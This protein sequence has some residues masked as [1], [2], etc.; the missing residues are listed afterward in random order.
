M[1][2][3]DYQVNSILLVDDDATFH[4]LLRYGLE[5]EGLSVEVADS[6]AAARRKM[7]AANFALVVLDIGLPDEDGLALL[8]QI[9]TRTDVPIMVI[10]GQTDTEIVVT[11]LELGANDF[12]G[13]PFDPRTV[14]LKIK[15]LATTHTDTRVAKQLSKP[16]FG[17]WTLDLAGRCLRARDGLPVA[18]TPGE[19]KIL[20][21]LVA[22]P[23]QALSRS[24][25]LDIVSMGE[26]GPTPR[27]I[28]VFITGL[29]NKLE[30]NRNKPELITTVRGYGYRFDGKFR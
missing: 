12:V 1:L 6:A 24:Q 23:G 25:L 20:A 30:R 14:L 18:L 22:H 28:D 5:K 7:D 4:E 17:E 21:A 29:R 27:M 13:K 11:A 15:R 2:R 26:D 19:F 16:R 10:S 3:K 8:R 9:R